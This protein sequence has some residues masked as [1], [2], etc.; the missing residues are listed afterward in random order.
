MKLIDLL[1]KIANKEDL[2]KK[3]AFK[4]VVFNLNGNKYKKI[5]DIH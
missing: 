1:V 3:I 2:P 4:D 5:M